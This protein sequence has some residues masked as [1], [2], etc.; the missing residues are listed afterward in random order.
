MKALFVKSGDT[1][2]PMDEVAIKI[3]G[4]YHPGDVVL[5]E[6]KFKRNAG[7]HRRFFEFRNLTFDL[8]DVYQDKEIWRKVLEINAGHFELVID[9]DGT[10]HYW[11]KSIAWDEMDE[12]E[13][14]DLFNRVV[15]G[16]LE[17]YG[18]GISQDDLDT[19]VAF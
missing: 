16:F 8:Q 18:E 14:A 11:P 2:V 15:N 12:V 4:K 7:N 17:K 5:V 19:V 13:F 6:H 3:M 10:A 1:L 9:K